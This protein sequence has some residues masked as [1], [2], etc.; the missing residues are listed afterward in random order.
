V[1]VQPDFSYQVLDLEE[2]ENHSR[3]YSYPDDVRKNA[4]NAVEELIRLIEAR[5]FPFRAAS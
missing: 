4:Y 2:F 5:D 3:L 1:L